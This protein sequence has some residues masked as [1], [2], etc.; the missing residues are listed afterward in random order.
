MTP[1][2]ACILSIGRSPYMYDLAALLESEGVTVRVY[3]ND[4]HAVFARPLPGADVV[5]MN[6]TIY[7]EW[8]AAARWADG[9]GAH[10]LLLND[11]IVMPPGAAQALGEALDARPDFGLISVGETTE[12]VAP[13]EVVPVAHRLGNR[14]DF[15]PWC[16]IARTAAWQDVDP[17]YRIWYGD[18]D[19]MFKVHDAG[20]VVGVLRGV[21]VTHHVST[22]SREI[23]WVGQA[24]HDDG[25]LWAS[26]HP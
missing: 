9:L 21:G 3:V 22:T 12:V 18:D 6:G 25:V 4:P 15:H 13:T 5:Y 16:C 14:R 24:A 17:R 8:N 19:L 1:L 26:L 7:E 23:D 11:D 20:W 2:A 10:L